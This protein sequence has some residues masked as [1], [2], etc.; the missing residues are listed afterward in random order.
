MKRVGHGGASAVARANT[1]ESF[2]AALAIGVDMI[3]FDVRSC[4]RGALMLAHTRFDLRRP[5]CPSLNAALRHVSSPRFDGVALNLDLKTP[6][7]EAA[8]V[9]AIDRFGLQERVLVSSQV[10]SIL[11]GVRALDGR[12]ATGISVGGCV[13]RWVRRWGDWR[14]AVLEAIAGGRFRSLMAQYGLI[15]PT[16]VHA[17]KERGAEIYAWTVNDRDSIV[18]LSGLGVDGIVTG[19]PRLFRPGT[20]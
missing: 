20:T 7:C 2:D 19:D 8:V 14:H 12:V 11:D 13:S 10:P 6:G 5:G 18:R 3:E 1:L 16:L 4:T 17:V 15:D 9:D